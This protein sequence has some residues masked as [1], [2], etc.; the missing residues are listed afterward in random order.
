MRTDYS[1]IDAA[2]MLD[3][4]LVT[5]Q[6]CGCETLPVLRD[7]RLVGLLTK[8]NVGEFLAIQAALEAATRG[9]RR[10]AGQPPAM[11][12]RIGT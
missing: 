9:A 3:A 6:T 12:L 2:G 5:M 8:H 10:S 4:A 11:P 7:G 1:A